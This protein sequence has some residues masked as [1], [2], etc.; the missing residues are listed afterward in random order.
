M[1]W[2]SGI[3]AAGRLF[4]RERL[5]LAHGFTIKCAVYGALAARLAQVP[6]RVNAVAGMGYVSSSG[7]QKTR[8]LRPLVR[9]LLRLA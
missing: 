3:G 5:A 4:R 9:A 6:A 2:T 7:D 8:A 1:Y